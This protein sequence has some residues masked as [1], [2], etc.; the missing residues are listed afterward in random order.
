MVD[1]TWSIMIAMV[2]GYILGLR[3]GY[4][5]HKEDKPLNPFK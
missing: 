5:R 1:I 3:Q 4:K 2:A